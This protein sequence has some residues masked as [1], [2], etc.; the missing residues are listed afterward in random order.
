MAFTTSHS[1]SLGIH[2]PLA[3]GTHNSHVLLTLLATLGQLIEW[4]PVASGFLVSAIHLLAF[5]A[6]WSKG[7]S[8]RD[9][10]S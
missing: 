2:S 5:R 8:H 1:H 10:G 3:L 4:I 9:L 6:D 7:I